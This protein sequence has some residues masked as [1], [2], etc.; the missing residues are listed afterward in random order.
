MYG[1]NLF[2]SSLSSSNPFFGTQGSEYANT[3]LLDSYNKLENLRRQQ[4][5]TQQLQNQQYHQFTPSTVFS[6]I[7]NEMKEMGEDEA[8]FVLSS[9]EYQELNSRHQREFSE[10]ITEK[11]AN[12]YIQTGRGRTLEEMLGVIRKKK[13]QYKSKFAEDISEIK[14]ANK[15]LL[16]KNNE[17]AMNN[18]TLQKQLEEIQK[19]LNNDR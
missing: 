15:D 3:P 8:N 6:D 17:L 9:K 2:N 16:D 13:D 14:E 19:R 1:N 12:E 5:F 11:F 4:T 18:A 7:A 10:F